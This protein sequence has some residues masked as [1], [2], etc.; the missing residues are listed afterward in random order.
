[1]RGRKPKPSMLHAL[2][3]LPGDR[4][5]PKDEPKP[6]GD[7]WEAP[8]WMSDKQQESWR[9]AIANAPPGLLK[10]IDRGVL[11]VWV[12]AE[13]VHREA[14]ARQARSPLVITAPVTGTPMQSPFIGVMNRQA[15]IM[16]KAASELGF[17][18]VSRPRISVP[19]LPAIPMN[20]ATRSDA[21]PA[22]KRSLDEF[23]AAAPPTTLN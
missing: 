19:G 7:L 11:A 8:D 18:P 20:P 16:L 14:A 4:P 15:Q 12:A 5:L 1:M 17:S 3:G 10:R 23:L 22:P 21:S 2:H 6:V 9:Y 13:T